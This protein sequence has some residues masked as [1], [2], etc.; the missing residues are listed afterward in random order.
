LV[1][2]HNTQKLRQITLYSKV[3]DP[4]RTK[5]R[6]GLVEELLGAVGAG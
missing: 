6:R 3:I 2:H 1:E 4:L 5:K